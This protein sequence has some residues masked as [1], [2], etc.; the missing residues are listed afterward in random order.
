MAKDYL[1][2]F[3]Q[4][5]R[6]KSE[7]DYKNICWKGIGQ[8]RKILSE[9]ENVTLTKYLNGWLNTGHQ[10]GHLGEASECP[11]CGWHEETQ[12]HLF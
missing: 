1:N 12:L 10:K 4:E 11:C 8:A 7:D 5:Y 3:L 6:D 9:K 2:F